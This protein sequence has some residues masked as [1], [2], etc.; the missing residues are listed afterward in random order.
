MYVLNYYYIYIAAIDIYVYVNFVYKKKTTYKLKIVYFLINLY[1]ARMQ[2]GYFV[3][4][5]FLIARRATARIVYA[6]IVTPLPPLY[7]IIQDAATVCNEQVTPSYTCAPADRNDTILLILFYF[8]FS[9][10]SHLSH[11]P[12]AR[13]PPQQQQL[14]THAHAHTQILYR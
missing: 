5:F 6:R 8:L 1:R 12:S 10:V 13:S 9:I 4:F 3:R 2:R 14:H 7:Y 11:G